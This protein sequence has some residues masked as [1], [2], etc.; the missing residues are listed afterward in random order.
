MNNPVHDALSQKAFREVYIKAKSK[1]WPNITK[2][3]LFEARGNY[4]KRW[5]KGFPF[6]GLKYVIGFSDSQGFGREKTHQV[7]DTGF[8][9]VRNKS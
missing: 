7:K 1:R 4:N 3:D 2:Y 8:R 6:G 5:T 9:V